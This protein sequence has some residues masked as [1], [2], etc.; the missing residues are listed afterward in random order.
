MAVHSRDNTSLQ[1]RLNLRLQKA[2]QQF[3]MLQKFLLGLRL[4]MM[5][6]YFQRLLMYR[7]FLR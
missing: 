2:E 7:E 3:Y 1:L 6:L 5:K 4:L